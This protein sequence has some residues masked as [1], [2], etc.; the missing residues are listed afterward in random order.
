M[1]S[2]NPGPSFLSLWK[3]FWCYLAACPSDLVNDVSKNHILVVS[4][5]AHLL[6]LWVLA[7]PNIV[8]KKGMTNA[9]MLVR[10]AS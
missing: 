6:P 9:G 2:R 5:T 3:K 7:K 4:V 8:S 1:L 10:L